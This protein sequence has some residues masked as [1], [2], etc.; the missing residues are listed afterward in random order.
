[1]SDCSVLVDDNICYLKQGVDLLRRLSDE[2]YATKLPDSYN[3]SVGG[4][5]RHC[6]DH[7]INF[8][9]GF[10]SGKVDYD[11]RAR[12]T[13]IEQERAFALSSM[14]SLSQRLMAVRTEDAD[15][16][17]MVK[18]DCGD[19]T[20]SATLWS[21]SSLRREFQFLVSHT[22]HHYALIGMML[23]HQGIDT[24]KEF[25]IAPSTLRYMQSQSACAR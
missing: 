13:R 22:V 16:P 6:L 11:A 5:M 3:S 1:M 24:G 12:D 17:V 2:Q 20:D 15:K 4:H 14:D 21:A 19:D 7:Y 10:E 25:G 18:M 23:K 8:L 9:D